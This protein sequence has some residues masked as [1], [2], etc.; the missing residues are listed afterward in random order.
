M[1]IVCNEEFG[2]YF[3]SAV[4]QW[5]LRL[6]TFTATIVTGNAINVLEQVNNIMTRNYLHFQDCLIIIEKYI[7]NKVNL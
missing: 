6:N 7:T 3:D 2:K 1:L 5:I 4:T